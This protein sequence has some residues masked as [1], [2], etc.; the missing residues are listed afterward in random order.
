MSSCT[1][2][3]GNQS[4]VGTEHRNCDKSLEIEMLLLLA[5][6]GI[7]IFPWVKK[8]GK[9]RRWPKILNGEDKNQE[10]RVTEVRKIVFQEG[11]RV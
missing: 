2:E 10:I 4:K 9:K 7:G 3:S 5:C 8:K 1:C 11:G 6:N